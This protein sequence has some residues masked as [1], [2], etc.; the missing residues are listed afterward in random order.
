L[1]Y[2]I[3]VAGSVIVTR[4]RRRREAGGGGGVGPAAV[5][6]L[7]LLAGAGSSLQAQVPQRPRPPTP[8]A[9]Q[10]T[11]GRRGAVGRDTTGPGQVLDTAT[12]ARLGLPTG[13]TRTF[14]AADSLLQALQNRPG[15]QSIRYSADSAILLAPERRILLFGKGVTKRGESILEADNRIIFDDA[16]C[17][18]FAAGEPR[19]FDG[20]SV[21]VADSIRYNTCT[22]RAVVADALTNFQEG[23]ALWFLR[24]NLAQDS[25]SSRLYASS[26]EITSCDLPVP[27]YHFAARE[28]KWISK[29]V[30]VARPAVLY[31]RDVP[32]LWL[33][34]IF[35]DARPGRRSGILV[36]QFGIN[37]IVRP[38]EGYNRQVTNIGYYWAPNDYI[39]LT[40]RMDWYANRYIQFGVYGQYRWLNRFLNGNIGYSRTSETGG[41]RNTAIRWDHTQNFDLSTSLRLNFNYASNSRVIDRNST[42]PFLS[43]QE[44]TSSLNFTKRFG[45][46]SMTL[47][48]NR[49]QSLSDKSVRQQFPAL[50]I[51]PKPIDISRNV[52]W[53]PALT[54]TNDVSSNSPLP[55]FT[56]VNA[57]GGIDT[58]RATADSRTTAFSLDTPLRIGGF[59]WRNSLRMTD[60]KSN[61]REVVTFK[62][63]NPATADPTDSVSV[64]RVYDGNF[65]TGLD[66]DTGINLPTLLR[67]S[68]K[69]QPALTI[70]NVV[71][72]QPFALRNWNTG[73]SYVLQGKR[74]AVS[75]SASPT[76]FGFWNRPIGPVG[77]IRHSISPILNY[78]YRPAAD[79]P[80]DFAE[81]VAV[82]G[83]PLRLRTDQSQTASIGLSQVFEGKARP[84]PGDTADPATL[85]KF[86]ILSLTTSPI[87]YD[88]EQAKKPGRTGWTTQS[89]TNT[90]QSDLL[91]GFNLSLTHDLWRGTVGFDTA[92]FDPFLANLNASFS[93]TGG[94][95]RSLLSIFGL[96]GGGDKPATSP[97]QSP[98][99][100]S[101]VGDFGRRNRPGAFFNTE[102]VGLGRGRAFNASVNFS[103]AR[104]RPVPG[105]PRP[106]NRESIA[107]NTSFSPTP[108]WSVAWSTQYNITDSR[109]ESHVVRLERDMHE[110]RASFNFTRSPNG[111]FQ[112]YF[113]IFLTAL[114][115]VK[116]DY[117]QTTI[118]RP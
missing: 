100:A 92:Q 97:G 102:E 113:N 5:I 4:R 78:T 103:L 46:G 28:V 77:R 1:L 54:L 68:L 98:P 57:A 62:E 60:R 21:L 72:G 116:F 3:G 38:N 34:F 17:T 84:A 22:K 47:G 115:D 41:S 20:P 43:T 85:R 74:L 106:E 36:P 40:G 53:S 76:L 55:V 16:T 45:W 8:A 18:L 52:T 80:R 56:S 6:L 81:A 109:F 70:D 65:S 89:I 66:W 91:P 88:F 93:L 90:V 111:N 94:T 13:P 7:A 104:T 2:E 64:T 29:T 83:Q 108:L 19:L 69:L 33:P 59:N 49:R 58:V 23:S 75:F 26:S 10:D 25:S 67:S 99:P 87:A 73:G 114:P 95:F 30:M 48:G 117:D 50:T 9:G 96:G 79:I 31:I 35:Q 112:F 105:L 11:T 51:S 24:G 15:Y 61:A 101:Y 86:R 71:S 14:P 39:D 12:A 110:W 27:H 63:D 37:D 82:P 44:I 107:L 32:V 42:D 118:E